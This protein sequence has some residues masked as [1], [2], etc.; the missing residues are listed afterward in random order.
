MR[1]KLR[2]S[3]WRT[4]L[5]LKKRKQDV[6]IDMLEGTPPT[7]PKNPTVPAPGAPSSLNTRRK[8]TVPFA[9][10]KKRADSSTAQLEK[11]LFSLQPLKVR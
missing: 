7:D 6:Y 1:V 8:H 2:L 5:T 4:H 3:R 9:L 10:Q 11:G